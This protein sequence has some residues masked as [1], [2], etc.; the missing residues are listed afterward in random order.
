MYKHKYYVQ[1]NLPKLYNHFITL[2]KITTDPFYHATC[3]HSLNNNII[4]PANAFVISNMTLAVTRLHNICC[5][6]LNGY[7]IIISIDFSLYSF[8]LVNIGHVIQD[9]RPTISHF[10]GLVH[11]ARA[12]IKNL[13]ESSKVFSG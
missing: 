2:P 8:L 6:K 11:K 1:K 10:N 7:N 13:T 5:G 12:L 4:K 3:H 9:N